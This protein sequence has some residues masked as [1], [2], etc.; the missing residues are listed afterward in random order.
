[1]AGQSRRMANRKQWRELAYL[2]GEN[3]YSGNEKRRI[4]IREKP[5][6]LMANQLYRNEN[7][8]RRKASAKIGCQ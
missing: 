1:M 4:S 5:G 7:I 6:C 3:V 8:N 2:C